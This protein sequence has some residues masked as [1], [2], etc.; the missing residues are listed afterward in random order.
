MEFYSKKIQL[1]KNAI[2]DVFSNFK[3]GTKFLVFG[4]GHDSKMWYNGNAETY[5][6]ENKDEFIKLNE[7]DIPKTNIIKYDYKNISL[8]ISKEL[9]D[10][11]ISKFKVPDELLQLAPFDIILIDGP[12]GQAPEKPGRLLP[13]YWVK[14][15]SKSG[16]IIYTDDS[17]RPY[18]S[19][20][21]NKYFKNKAKSMDLGKAW[22]PPNSI[23]TTIP[24]RERQKTSR[25]CKI[26]Y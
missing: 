13:Y 15:L 26:I 24:L 5:F 3:S 17:R 6:V 9:S 21:I 16:T 1:P 22:L 19:Y 10:E 12:E 2:E 23:I 4:L 11:A 25:V 8:K 14:F 7:K 20:F 18:E